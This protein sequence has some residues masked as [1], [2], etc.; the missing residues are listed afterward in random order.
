MFTRLTTTLS[1]DRL[2]H[3]GEHLVAE[4]NKIEI[5]SLQ[6]FSKFLHRNHD[7][8]EGDLIY[9]LNYRGTN[10]RESKMPYK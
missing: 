10:A 8:H 5:N 9:G 4:N 3:D 1:I 2:L 6:G 7:S